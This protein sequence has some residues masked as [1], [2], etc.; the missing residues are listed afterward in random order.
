M[1]DLH[2]Q[3]PIFSLPYQS[4]ICGLRFQI[5]RK[6]Y[7]VSGLLSLCSGLYSV[8]SALCSLVTSICC[9][10]S[11]A[12]ALCFMVSGLRSSV[13]GR[14]Y[15]ASLCLVSLLLTYYPRHSRGGRRRSLEP[16]LPPLQPLHPRG[17]PKKKRKK[18]NEKRQ[19]QKK[20][21]P[22]PYHPGSW[23][24]DFFRTQPSPAAPID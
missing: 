8:V 19:Q 22:L 7:L 4:T 21:A 17:M 24:R 11:L 12:S 5:S 18:G 10:R 1:S 23:Q 14:W 16:A 13:S 2:Y 15:M 6:C 9:L 20:T 3:S